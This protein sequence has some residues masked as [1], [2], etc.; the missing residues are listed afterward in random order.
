MTGWGKIALGVRIAKHPEPLFFAS[1]TRLLVD[2]LRPGD[3]VLDPAVGLRGH[4]AAD[5]LVRR[6]LRSGCDT[7]ALFDDDM[8]FDV[9]ALSRL[10]D[11]VDN[12][13]YDVVSALAMR[14]VWPYVPVIMRLLDPQPGE[15]EARRGE[16]YRNVTDWR[17]GEVLPVDAVGLAFTLVKRQVLE[18]M[19]D[20]GVSD[21]LTFW[22]SP[23]AGD[24][25]D[26][27]GF[28]RQ[29]RQRGYTLAVDTLCELGHVA[30]GPVVVADW[31]RCERE[32]RELAPYGGG[33]PNHVR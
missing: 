11:H 9:L 2:G 29:V 17:P 28:S 3:V 30:H 25:S 15:P 24:E 14:R 13:Q 32:A 8:T 22:F 5:A 33:V 27:I 10:R 6:F 18:S 19:R 7:L 4:H 1:W 21:D 16:H 20:P 26:E 31:R 23:G 12:W